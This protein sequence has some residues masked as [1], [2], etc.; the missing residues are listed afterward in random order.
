MLK[1]LV[2]HIPYNFLSF[3]LYIC[4]DIE[5]KETV[6]GAEYRGTKSTTATGRTCQ[7]WNIQS[8]HEHTLVPLDEDLEGNNFVRVDSHCSTLRLGI[9]PIPFWVNFFHFDA[10]FEKFGQIIDWSLHLKGWCPPSGKS[11]ISH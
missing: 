11:W 2:V 5:C 9:R 6:K 7:A 8:P 4:A 3:N 1:A 10:A